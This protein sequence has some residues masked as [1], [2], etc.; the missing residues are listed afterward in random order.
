MFNDTNSV[1]NVS[2]MISWLAY[3][4]SDCYLPYYGIKSNNIVTI[5]SLG[6][7]MAAFGRSKI[8]PETEHCLVNNWKYFA[9]VAE[10]VLF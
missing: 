6:L 3:F 2:L 10:S 8:Y 4:I 1:V 7:F 9:F 5:T